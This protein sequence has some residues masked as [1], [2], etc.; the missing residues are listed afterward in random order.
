MGHADAA[1]QRALGAGLAV[2]AGDA[3]PLAGAVREGFTAHLGAGGA[4]EGSGDIRH[5]AHRD[6]HRRA[7]DAAR[8]AV[9]AMRDEDEI[10]DDAFHLI[11]EELD[12]LEMAA[13]GK[14]R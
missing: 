3:S 11:E 13:G 6:L 10:G 9:F 5:G 12:R 4:A 2:L 1:R 7:L 14:E 8:R